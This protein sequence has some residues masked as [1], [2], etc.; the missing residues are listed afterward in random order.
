MLLEYSVQKQQWLQTVHI[1]DMDVVVV[2][3]MVPKWVH[4]I[5]VRICVMGWKAWD[6]SLYFF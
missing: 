1:V 5:L 4:A 3:R 6:T 2:I